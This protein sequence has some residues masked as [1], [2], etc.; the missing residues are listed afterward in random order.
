MSLF[1]RLAIVF[2][3]IICAGCI[4][5]CVWY[6]YIINYGSD[7]VVSN[8]YE[9]G[10]QTTTNDDSRYF[11]EIQYYA[12][13][14]NSGYEM[15]D[16]KFNYML[17]ENQ[18]AF[19]SQGLQFVGNTKQSNLKFDYMVDSSR[20][21]EGFG[22]HTGWY[23]C[24][25]YY[26]YWGTY[27]LRN[28]T[29]NVFNYASGNDY[30]SVSL[31][32]N[33]ISQNSRFKIQ[34][35]DDLFLMKFKNQDTIPT[36]SNF[37]YKANGNY[38]FY[39]V[40]GTQDINYYY[41]YYD[42]NY[43]CKLL[44]ENVVKSMSAGTN[45]SLIFE[46]GDLFDYYKYD[47]ENCQYSSTALKNVDSVINDL[48]SYYS[49]KVTIKENGAQK[50]SDS[51]F[52][53][54]KGSTNFNSTGNYSSDDYFVGRSII[55]VNENDFDL[56]EIE[57]GY[58]NLKLKSSFVN[59]YSKFD[60]IKLKVDVNLDFYNAN[61]ITILGFTSDNGLSDFDVLSCYFSHTENGQVIKTEVAYV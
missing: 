9:V 56:V 60:T 45:K 2:G 24:Q 22:T 1:K 33:P 57:Q 34:L 59:Y 14:D 44:Y 18:E 16:V 39:L 54:M 35:G 53:A 55:S 3:T 25:D 7:K 20:L 13:K 21:A 42:V 32:T 4:G 12:N 37:V 36:Q 52:N 27:Q 47:A 29:G 26:R 50:S 61:D 48:K 58:C 6:Y 10:L 31:S 8:T 5:V 17:D 40:Y 19:Y 38:H 41:S 49:I 30:N 11:I 46:F 23:D 15:M 43:F 51:L 28:S